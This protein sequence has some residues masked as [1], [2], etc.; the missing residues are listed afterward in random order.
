MYFVAAMSLNF[1]LGGGGRGVLV[2]KLQWS[3]SDFM[4]H[5]YNN[6][7]QLDNFFNTPHNMTTAF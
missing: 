7:I 4:I 1:K 3:F 5:K 2:M 6:F